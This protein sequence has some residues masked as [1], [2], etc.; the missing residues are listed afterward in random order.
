MGLDLTLF[1]ADWERLRAFPVEDRIEALDEAMWPPDDDGRLCGRGQGWQWPPGPEA[2][3]CAVYEFFTTTGSYRPHWH[4]GDGWA[5][6]RPLADAS[7]REAVDVFLGGLIWDAVPAE[8]P[9][10]T[11]AGGFFPP[12]ADPRH[13]HLLL[14]GPPEAVRAKA[15][16]WLR[17]E[18]CLDLLRAPFAAE[19][20]GWAGRPESFEG[21][22]ALLREWGDVVTEAARRGWGLVGV[23]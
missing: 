14:A 3:W 21:F 13:P 12:A 8:D 10:L 19:C 18:P 15:D 1:M 20:E 22:V 5:D 4:A 2:A 23:P 17:A 16:A 7:L 6:M 9:A 11:G